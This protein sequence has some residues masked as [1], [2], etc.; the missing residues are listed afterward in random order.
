MTSFSCNNYFTY[1]LRMIILD[2]SERA[3]E[4]ATTASRRY[5][6]KEKKK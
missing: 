1:V 5:H 6:P 4:K 2:V 3:R